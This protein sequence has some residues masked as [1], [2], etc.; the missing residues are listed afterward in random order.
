M[1][2][3]MV[4]LET[5][6]LSP[7]CIIL[8]LGACT[9]DTDTGEVGEDVFYQVINR[10]SCLQ[11]GL[12]TE[13]AALKWWEDQSV[14]ARAVLH[15]SINQDTSSPLAIVLGN[16]NLWIKRLQTEED[17]LVEIW[18]NGSDFDNAILQHTYRLLELPTPYTGY[19]ARCYRTLKSIVPSIKLIRQGTLHNAIDDAMSQAEHTVTIIDSLTN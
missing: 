3:I 19:N 5:L 16:F 11:S 1:K 2:R 6:G 8:S 14:A 15:E 7:G 9:F 10:D 13:R 18:G 12:R 4:D 17:E